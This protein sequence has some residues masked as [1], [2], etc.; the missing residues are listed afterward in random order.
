MNETIKQA[1][2]DY[3]ALL[4]AE[5]AKNDPSRWQNVLWF[6]GH[7]LKQMETKEEHKVPPSP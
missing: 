5:E 2:S 1:E 7:I 3:R 4:Q 6:A